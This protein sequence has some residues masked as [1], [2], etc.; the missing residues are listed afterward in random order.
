MQA[1]TNSK[2][3]TT[4][5]DLKRLTVVVRHGD[6]QQKLQ[7][8]KLTSDFCKIVETYSASQQVSKY[9]CSLT[10]EAKTRYL[11]EYGSKLRQK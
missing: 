4:K 2:I 1:S 10:N 11:L 6:K 3:E 9:N 7:V 5:E 8:E